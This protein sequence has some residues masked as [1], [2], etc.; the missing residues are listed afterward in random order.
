MGH[1][2]VVKTA[3]QRVALLGD[4]TVA[5]TVA[6]KAVSWAERMDRLK[7][8]SMDAKT[9]VTMDASLA[10]ARA[11]SKVASWVAPRD[12]ETAG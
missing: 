1:S 10:G 5:T 8:A 12:F 4:L 9:A 11:A 2:R 7:A 6:K 3:V